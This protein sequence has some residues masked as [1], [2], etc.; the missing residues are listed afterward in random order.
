MSYRPPLGKIV[1]KGNKVNVLYS[2]VEE[3]IISTA[4]NV[5]RK[6][7]IVL[8]HK[9]LAHVGEKYLIELSK[10]GVFN[11]GKIGKFNFCE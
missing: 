11:G 6:S 9:R 1:M 7:N 10:K 3:S 5:M 2:L 8:W 4:N